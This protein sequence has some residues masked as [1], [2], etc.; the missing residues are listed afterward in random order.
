MLRAA[1]GSTGRSCR[2]RLRVRFVRA[3]VIDSPITSGIVTRA[4]GTSRRTS[5]HHRCRQ[6]PHFPPT[7]PFGRLSAPPRM[8]NSC[9]TQR[10][11]IHLPEGLGPWEEVWG[12]DKRLA[13]ALDEKGNLHVL[14]FMTRGYFFVDKCPFWVYC[15][16]VQYM[17]NDDI[18]VR[19]SNFPL[20]ILSTNYISYGTSLFLFDTFHSS[21]VVIGNAYT[22]SV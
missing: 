21:S 6:S 19:S 3:S 20:K 22:R 11:T 14:I 7:F 16:V 12:L 5:R 15:L 9:R 13:D 4:L 8:A 10:H 17:T 18:R 1:G 2:V